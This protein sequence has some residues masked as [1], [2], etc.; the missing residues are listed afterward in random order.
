[1]SQEFD[2]TATAPAA[3]A[4]RPGPFMFDDFLLAGTTL[5][6]ALVPHHWATTLVFAAG[7][8][9]GWPA[10][11]AGATLWAWWG[12]VSGA[13][14][15]GVGAEAAVGPVVA[16]ISFALLGKASVRT[17][18]TLRRPRV[19][20]CVPTL[21]ALI[22]A[23]RQRA[24]SDE[25]PAADAVVPEVIVLG[26]LASA[27]LSLAPRLGG[28]GGT[29][30]RPRGWGPAGRIALGGIALVGALRFAQLWAAEPRDQLGLAAALHA[31]R[32][33]LDRVL[34]PGPDSPD[35]PRR[36]DFELMRAVPD[37]DLAAARVGWRA[38]LGL[39]W[40][41]QRPS[42]DV[43]DIAASLDAR[44]R[45][46]EALRLLARYP[47]TGV[48][49]FWRAVYERAQGQKDGWRGGVDGVPVLGPA[50]LTLDWDMVHD[51][52][53][54]SVFRVERPVRATLRA[55][56]ESFQGDP[57]VEVRLDSA[58]STWVP[59]G[60]LDLGELGAGPHTLTVRYQTDLEGAGGDRNVWV[61]GL[62]AVTK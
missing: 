38:A 37:S 11:C 3:G 62:E 47:R 56:M 34:A 5:V 46:G 52:D 8:I 27:V 40:R 55:R 22:L 36:L 7:A 44:G 61:S 25:L 49:D 20:W 53:R 9:S 26:L 21:L 17:G 39:G 12:A 29:A 2:H 50:G 6:A 13:A 15:G 19:E 14:A 33:V 57:T 32:L 51:E 59:A 30:H 10:L 60:T 16:A 24:V 43:V 48:I 23:A 42:S 28:P 45:G 58:R 18:V 4:E 35:E 1:M 41:P 31:E 54:S